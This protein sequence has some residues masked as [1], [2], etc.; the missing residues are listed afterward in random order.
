[1]PCRESFKRCRRCEFPAEPHTNYQL[2]KVIERAWSKRNPLSQ[3]S[4]LDALLEGEI[5]NLPKTTMWPG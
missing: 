2:F 1:M 4:D 5:Q 3:N